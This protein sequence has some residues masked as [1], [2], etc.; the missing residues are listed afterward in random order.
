MEENHD[1]CAP[2]FQPHVVVVPPGFNLTVLNSEH[3]AHNFHTTP[4][5]ATNPGYNRMQ[6]PAD[7]KAVLKGENTFEAVA[8]E[9]HKSRVHTWTPKH[10]QVTWPF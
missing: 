2:Q 5:D 7:E 8:R 9:W 4:L 6:T 10:G 3:A 1:A